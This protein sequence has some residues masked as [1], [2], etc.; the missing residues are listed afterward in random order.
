MRY[1]ET[2]LASCLTLYAGYKAELEHATYCPDIVTLRASSENF[3][4]SWPGIGEVTLNSRLE[5]EGLGVGAVPGSQFVTGPSENGYR[6]WWG[7][8]KFERKTNWPYSGRSVLELTNAQTSR[9]GFEYPPCELARDITYRYLVAMAHLKAISQHFARY[10]ADSAPYWG[11]ILII[12]AAALNIPAPAPRSAHEAPTESLTR[13]QSTGN[14]PILAET[15]SK[16]TGPS[17]IR[18]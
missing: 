8:Q 2:N 11:T 1:S 10:A 4:F 16:A 14:D 15:L 3:V 18:R 7:G 13:P 9:L 6:G 12:V 17:S 5:L